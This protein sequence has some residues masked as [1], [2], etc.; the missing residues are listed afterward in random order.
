M[1]KPTTTWSIAK[2][3]CA[4]SVS[5]SLALVID[6]CHVTGKVRGLLCNGCNTAL[7][8]FQDDP[9]VLRRAISYLKGVH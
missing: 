8:A 9:K 7:G 6:H 2:V 1:R 4:P 3:V 5:A